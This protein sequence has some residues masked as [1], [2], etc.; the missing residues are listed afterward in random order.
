MVRTCV[1]WLI[2]KFFLSPLFLGASTSSSPRG[3]G[4]QD[5]NIPSFFQSFPLKKLGT[6]ELRL[7]KVIY[8]RVR[9]DPRDGSSLY[10]CEYAKY[11]A[12]QLL[13]TFSFILYAY[14]RMYSHIR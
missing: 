12:T 5:S 11:A 13:C 7:Y 4:S 14:V 8:G 6:W 1:L 3:A 9:P 10:S 2:N